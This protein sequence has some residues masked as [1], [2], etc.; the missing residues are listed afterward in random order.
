MDCLAGSD[1]DSVAGFITA[2]MIEPPSPRPTRTC[3]V[4]P[5]SK[6]GSDLLP[7]TGFRT[8]EKSRRNVGKIQFEPPVA[9]RQTVAG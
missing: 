8:G 4:H 7:I 6:A 3:M 2:A 1:W 5:Y 9:D